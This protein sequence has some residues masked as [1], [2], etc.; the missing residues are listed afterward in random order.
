ML[1]FFLHREEITD[2]EKWSMSHSG[3]TDQTNGNKEHV[4]IE[5]GKF[6][7]SNT[8][9]D[10]SNAKNDHELE[11]G[12][13][14]P[15]R[16]VLT[17]K[18]VSF[19]SQYSISNIDDHKVRKSNKAEIM[20]A[21]RPPQHCN[22]ISDDNLNDSQIQLEKLLFPPATS[23]SDSSKSFTKHISLS[24][25]PRARINPFVRV[26]SS[27][28]VLDSSKSVRFSHE[29]DETFRVPTG[30]S[31]YQQQHFNFPSKF[32][33]ENESHEI[34]KP[35][36]AKARRISLA[37][38][39]FR[40]V[41]PS[42]QAL[43]TSS[44]DQQDETT[45]S[46]DRRAPSPIMTSKDLRLRQQ[47]LLER[48]A[49][50]REV[51]KDQNVKLLS[52][53]NECDTTQCAPR[54][55]FRHLVN[56]ALVQKRSLTTG[57]KA[58]LRWKKAVSLSR[59]HSNTVGPLT[60]VKLAS[61]QHIIRFPSQSVKKPFLGTAPQ[62]R[63]ENHLTPS[64]PS[65]RST[66][67][68]H[69]TCAVIDTSSTQSNFSEMESV[70]VNPVSVQNVDRTSS[71]EIATPSIHEEGGITVDILDNSG[72]SDFGSSDSEA[73][74]LDECNSSIG[75]S[76]SGYDTTSTTVTSVIGTPMQ[77]EIN[78]MS[79]TKFTRSTA[80]DVDQCST[81]TKHSSAFHSRQSQFSDNL[82]PPGVE[83]VDKLTTNYR[84]Y[85][86]SSTTSSHAN[87]INSKRHPRSSTPSNSNVKCFQTENETTAVKDS[88]DHNCSKFTESLSQRSTINMPYSH[89][90]ILSASSV[91]PQVV[92]AKASFD[93]TS[94]SD[95][96]SHISSDVTSLFAGQ[97]EHRHNEK[98]LSTQL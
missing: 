46:S 65:A 44:N 22:I 98:C 26:H 12:V 94:E 20:E 11:L 18:K 86:H 84:P 23:G 32:L 6:D 58:K 80:L 13:T 41:S 63:S 49:L 9:I 79:H 8:I 77:E 85:S 7:A 70:V 35:S 96:I 76:W 40:S 16:S 91:V 54:S 64:S 31:Y 19:E 42:P 28:E 61:K 55:K 71:C 43:Y 52:Q 17:R 48:I 67:K 15:T 10:D 74:D 90:P 47:Q 89:R 29:G 33:D 97:Q 50:A 59:D 39:S 88:D 51:S 57:S 30:Q 34:W 83:V 53:V 1:L 2:L 27:G 60:A 37:A 25:V 75:C 14:S 82:S 3:T 78:T 38:H 21:D 92:T 56:A 5:L 95:I 68:T 66:L 4:E 81:V 24:N 72:C 93:N 87:V 36:K 73:G 69:V 45:S 62:S